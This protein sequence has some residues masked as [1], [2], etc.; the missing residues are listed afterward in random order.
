MRSTLGCRRL[1]VLSFSC[2]HLL[3]FIALYE[4]VIRPHWQSCLNMPFLFAAVVSIGALTVSAFL[5]WASVVGFNS[6]LRFDR[7]V[8]TLTYTSGV[9]ILRWRTVL[10]QIGSLDR[11][12]VER[13]D[14]SEGSPS[15]SMSVIMSDGRSFKSGASW[16]Q[17]EVEAIAKRV[18]SFLGK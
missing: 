12:D 2:S 9:P 15:Y 7:S 10:C 11:I 18:W 13:H 5:V 3:P 16:S 1:N 14:W 6:K 17:Q 8:G 4:L